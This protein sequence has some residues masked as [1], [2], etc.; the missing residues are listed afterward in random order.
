MTYDPAKAKALLKE[1]G[2]KGEKDSLH[3]C[4][5][6][7]PG[8]AGPRPSSRTSTMSASTWKSS[9]PTCPA[10]R[11]GSQLRLRPDLQLPLPARR[12]GDG[13]RALL[14]QQPTS[15]RA[16]HSA[17]SSG[18][19]NPEVDKLFAEGAIA[20][21]NE[22]PG[23]LHKGA[24]DPRRRAAG[25]WLLELDF[26]TITAAT[27][28]TSSRRRSASTTASA[29]RGS[30]SEAW[31]QSNRHVRS[32]DDFRSGLHGLLMLSF[33]A[34]GVVKGV[35]VLLAIA[36]LNFVLIRLAPGDPAAVMAGEAGA[37]DEVF[38]ASCARVRPRPAD[39]RAALPL[40]EGHCQ[41]DLGF[42]LPAAAAGL[43]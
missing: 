43:D 8:S 3:A 31:R 26:P 6:A 42:Q 10:G 36:V 18:Y 25:A 27:S 5:M 16:S 21:P 22:A 9:R 2:Y 13:R 1:A 28:R 30:T 19:S 38:V 12:P 29:M 14:R 39:A 41:L 7:R 17:M 33:V 35:V 20:P 4:P 40:R 15:S 37:G 11:S 24:A 34:L 23:D 32:P